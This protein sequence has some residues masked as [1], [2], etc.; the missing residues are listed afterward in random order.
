[1]DGTFIGSTGLIDHD[2][3]IYLWKRTGWMDFCRYLNSRYSIVLLV[4]A[5]IPV[6]LPEYVAAATDDPCEQTNDDMM[7]SKIIIN[8]GAFVAERNVVEIEVQ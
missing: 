7:S 6:S 5:V 3:V 8:S 1:M 4:C 2:G